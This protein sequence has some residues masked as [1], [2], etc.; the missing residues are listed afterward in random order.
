MIAGTTLKG[1]RFKVTVDARGYRT[2]WYGCPAC[3]CY[4]GIKI[5]GPSGYTWDGEGAHP[6]VIPSVLIS[7]IEGV[8]TCHHNITSGM[9]VFH[10]DSHHTLAGQ[11]RPMLKWHNE[12]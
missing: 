3:I 8:G 2:L 1:G 7:N 6:T 9:L 10:R 11:S 5:D 4:H 12:E